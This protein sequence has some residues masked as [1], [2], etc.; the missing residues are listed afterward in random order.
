MKQVREMDTGRK[1]F[2]PNKV[3]TELNGELRFRNH[4]DRERVEPPTQELN[5]KRITLGPTLGSSTH[6]TKTQREANLRGRSQGT[7]S[8]DT[9]P[10]D[11][12]PAPKTTAM[13]DIQLSTPVDGGY[14]L[15]TE[16]ERDKG[17]DKGE[18]NTCLTCLQ[19]A[20]WSGC[21]PCL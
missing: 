10:Q 2:R 6:G 15:D 16:A 12:H 18:L 20:S 13:L 1:H 4:Q 11:T 19:D 7:Q 3:T 17:E 21:R 5:Q 14:E 8:L 9:K